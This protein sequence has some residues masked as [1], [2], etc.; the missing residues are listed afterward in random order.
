MKIAFITSGTSTF[1]SKV[2]KNSVNSNIWVQNGF[3]HALEKHT[4]YC[5]FSI[6]FYCCTKAR[7]RNGAVFSLTFAVEK[8][9]FSWK[10][11]HNLL[12]LKNFEQ[13][14]SKNGAISNF[15]LQIDFSCAYE[16]HTCNGAISYH[17]CSWHRIRK[18]HGVAFH[19]IVRF[20]KCVFWRLFMQKP[21]ITSWTPRFSSKVTK[22][23]VNSNMILQKVYSLARDKHTYFDTISFH[24]YCFTKSRKRNGA[25]LLL[26]FAGEKF[27][28]PWKNYLNLL[29]LKHFEQRN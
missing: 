7:K 6:H 23:G 10:N 9:M 21:F 3:F 1:S 17:Y 15:K 24:F 16:K 13:L 11:Y 20:Q 26:A 18:L 25:V 14:S 28:F 27:M 29:N 12:N 2:T 5:T 4:H 22:N 8:C 19:R